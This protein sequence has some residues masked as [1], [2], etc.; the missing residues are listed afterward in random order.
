VSIL[1]DPCTR[2]V[3]Q[4]ITGQAAR[5]HVPLMRAYGTQVV[6]G[7]A[8]GRG[9][10]DLDGV[11]VFDTLDQALAAT[12][13]DTSLIMLPPRVAADAILEAF[14]AEVPLVVCV[15]EGVPIH[16]MLTVMAEQ[17]RTRSRLI[18]PNCPGL[19]SPGQALVGVMPRLLL[20]PGPVGLVSRSG[21]L[22]YEVSYALLEAGLGQT[23]WVGVG[24]DPIK[25][26]RFE[27]ILPLFADDPDT[28]VVAVLGEIGGDD[29]EGAAE[30]VVRGY[31]KPLVALVAGERAPRGK[32]V[33][34][35]GAIIAGATGDHA[36]KVAALRAAG[37]HVASSP[38]EL[39]ARALRLAEHGAPG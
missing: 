34:H 4:G 37:V 19:A 27:D 38:T 17:R 28:R 32:P 26:S 11:P 15:S 35:A 24:G 31:P 23:T 3:V 12:R 6:A 33:G 1:V 10:S 8:P 30:L 13:A 16:D 2:V 36:A 39:A 18:G 5:T 29:E 21:T 20:R 14:A 7:V 22:A 9:G 25:G